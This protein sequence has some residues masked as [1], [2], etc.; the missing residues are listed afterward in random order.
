MRIRRVAEPTV[1]PVDIFEA[2]DHLNWESDEKDVLITSYIAAARAFIENSCHIVLVE[3]G[4]ELSLDG[5]ADAEIALARFPL[6]DVTSIKYDDADGAEQ[7]LD[8]DTYTVDTSGHFGRIVVGDDGWPV[9]RTGINSVRIVF[10]AGWPNDEDDLSTAPPALKQA[11][12]LLVGHFFANREAVG[13]SD[14][15]LMPMAV[16]A[17]ISPYRIPVIA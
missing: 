5:F 6:I 12:L 16:E 11:I 8:A 15:A 3:S 1:E 14:M 13:S 9:T 10:T 4:W 2:R 7:T 17:L